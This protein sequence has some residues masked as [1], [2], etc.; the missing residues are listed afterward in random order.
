MSRIWKELCHYVCSTSLHL[1]FLPFLCLSGESFEHALSTRECFCESLLNLGKLGTHLFSHMW[2]I[3]SRMHF[4]KNLPSNLT[5]CSWVYSNSNGVGDL[6]VPKARKML[7]WQRYFSREKEQNTNKT[8]HVFFARL[9]LPH[10]TKH[11]R[12]PHQ[13]LLSILSSPNLRSHFA[14][15]FGEGT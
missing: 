11:Q 4:N 9:L 7:V 5:K 8:L 10:V 3:G 13:P 1:M 6:Q 12:I 14:S 2:S 15:E